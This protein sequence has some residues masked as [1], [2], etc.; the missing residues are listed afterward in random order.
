MKVTLNTIRQVLPTLIASDIVGVQPMTGVTGQTFTM[1]AQYQDPNI[2]K[3]HKKYKFSRAR[4]FVVEFDERNYNRVRDWCTEH[5][6]PHPRNPDAWSRWWH[7][8]E[9][10]IHF[11]YED[12]AV[13]FKLTWSENASS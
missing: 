5:F 10:S 6:G 7:R 12:D 4:W 1:R 8:Y 3:F 13:L 11:A 2:A 9:T